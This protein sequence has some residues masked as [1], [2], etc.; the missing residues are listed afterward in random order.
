MMVRKASM[1]FHDIIRKPITVR[2][3]NQLSIV[4]N[5]RRLLS[6]EFVITVH[7]ENVTGL[8]PMAWRLPPPTLD[9]GRQTGSPLVPYKLPRLLPHKGRVPGHS[10]DSPSWFQ[11]LTLQQWATRQGGDRERTR[12]PFPGSVCPPLKCG[13][14]R[15]PMQIR[16]TPV[17]LCL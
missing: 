2:Q 6:E 13:W 3:V 17:C 15:S 7:S 10:R 14:C 1:P 12:T 5:F 8:R 16:I 11:L 4:S 9:E